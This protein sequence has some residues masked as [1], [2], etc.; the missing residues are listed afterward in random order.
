MTDKTQTL[1]MMNNQT[2]FVSWGAIY[3]DIG[4]DTSTEI[5]N[6]LKENLKDDELMK[7]MNPTSYYLMLLNEHIMEY[8]IE[9][10]I[11]S[12]KLDNYKF[13]YI[14]TVPANWNEQCRKNLIKAA[15]M[16]QIIQ[17]NEVN[18]LDLID[19]PDAAMVFCKNLLNQ[20][21]GGYGNE[22]KKFILCD[23]GGLNVN[24]FTYHWNQ[25]KW[26]QVLE[27]N[28]DTC[29]SRNLN[30]RF[31]DYLW[32]FYRDVGIHMR[33]TEMVVDETVD[34]FEKVYKVQSSVKS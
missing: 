15:I 10:E 17:S 1:V 25:S 2:K 30:I 34:Y 20:Q 32:E 23:A 13:K 26:F 21:F 12:K 16:A 22:G 14:I 6:N 3:S 33:E 4:H 29:G 11:R 9:N 28:S 19:E 8:I 7:E 18:Y 5:F 27:G 24:V 31:R